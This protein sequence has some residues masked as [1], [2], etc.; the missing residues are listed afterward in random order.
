MWRLTKTWLRKAK[1]FSFKVILTFFAILW[2]DEVMFGRKR[3]M[4]A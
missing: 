4:A 3:F 2:P 1:Y